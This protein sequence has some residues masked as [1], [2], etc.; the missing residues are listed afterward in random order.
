MDADVIQIIIFLALAVF[1]LLRLKNVLGT[2]TGHENTERSLRIVPTRDVDNEK[3]KSDVALKPVPVA[4]SQLTDEDIR[5]YV[6]A[7]TEDKIAL[8]SIAHADPAFDIKDFLEGAKSAYEM[9]LN[10]FEEGDVQT[11]RTYVSQD[12]YAGFEEA[13][14]E[15]ETKGHTIDSKFIGVRDAQITGVEYDEKLLMADI[16]IRFVG[17]RTRAVRDATG[18]VIEGD[19]INIQRMADIWTF[20][21]KLDSADPN[22]ILTATD[23]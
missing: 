23:A 9:L 3:T 20:T 1:L 5:V 12:V 8:K 11:L 14:K 4:A 10:A 13:I 2:K 6:N 17:E 15:R 22:W 16:R 21:R 19:L 18:E 7:G